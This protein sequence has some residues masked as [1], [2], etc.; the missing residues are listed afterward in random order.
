MLVLE[1]SS[2]YFARN[3]SG[4]KGYNLYLMQQEGIAVPDWAILGKSVYASFMQKSGILHA[5]NK[6]TQA[7]QDGALPARQLSDAIERLIVETPLPDEI[8]RLVNEAYG[9]VGACGMISGRSSA[10]DE[11]GSAHS[12]AG[13]L[14]SYLYVSSAADAARFL[15]LC[16]AS[17]YSQ[18][19]IAYRV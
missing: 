15:K 19:S 1:N 6:L 10:V 2:E 11:D 18:R 17:A 7:F 16:W 3:E 14:S 8:V 12:F 9:R 5:I 4:G 13:Q